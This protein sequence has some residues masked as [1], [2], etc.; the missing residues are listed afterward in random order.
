MQ[1][2]E[3]ATR[4][5]FPAPLV[6]SVAVEVLYHAEKPSSAD[7]DKVAGW[8]QGVVAKTGGKEKAALLQQ[9]ASVL[10]L[11]GDF[12][13]SVARYR[14]TL[15]E[16]PGDVMALNNLAYLLSAH[17]KQHDQA[18]NYI[19]EAKNLAGEDPNLFDTEALIRI[20][21]REPREAR[22]AQQLMERVVAEAPSGMSFYHLA[23]AEDACGNSVE[24][25]RAWRHA[26]R[27][28]GVKKEDLHPLE[29][30]D[31]DR[32]RKKYD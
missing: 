30:G 7:V 13:G 1:M 32:I 2:W 22:A 24:A 23:L 27:D 28:L 18:L 15:A 9:L 19:R 26:S 14:D 29:H 6:G 17:L 10:S 4:G 25:R 11:R 8:L 3:E 16:N 12:D 5:K 20:N 31:F 21:K